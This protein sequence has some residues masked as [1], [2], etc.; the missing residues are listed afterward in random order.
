[1]EGGRQ[2]GFRLEGG[3]QGIGV[4]FSV[5]SNSSSKRANAGGACVLTEYQEKGAT[6]AR[7]VTSGFFRK[8]TPSVI[9]FGAG[10][11]FK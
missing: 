3:S 1:V 2:P 10:A 9:H 11:P 7:Q 8:G 4:P 5:V 6:S